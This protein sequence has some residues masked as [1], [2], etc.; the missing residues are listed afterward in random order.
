MK[1]KEYLKSKR[2]SIIKIMNTSLVS[3]FSCS[4]KF[5]LVRGKTCTDENSVFGFFNQNVSQDIYYENE[6]ILF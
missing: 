1:T 3:E 2:S 4:P 6:N 5:I